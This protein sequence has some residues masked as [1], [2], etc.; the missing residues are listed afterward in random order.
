MVLKYL[1]NAKNPTAR[2]MLDAAGSSDSALIELTP[3]Y[4]TAWDFTKTVES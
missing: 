1:G 3:L 2:Q 4:Y